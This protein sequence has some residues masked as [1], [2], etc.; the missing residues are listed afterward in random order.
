MGSILVYIL[1]FAVSLGPLGWLIISEIFPLKVRGLGMSI[2]SLSNWLFNAVVTFTFLKLAW[3]FTG[4]GMEISNHGA[5]VPPDP[6]PAGAFFVYAV[7]AILGIIWGIKYI[8]ETKGITLEEI[9]QHWRDGKAPNE[10]Q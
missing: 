10:L 3:L 7:I 5:D 8:P 2:G 4:P 1:F 9:E 6:N